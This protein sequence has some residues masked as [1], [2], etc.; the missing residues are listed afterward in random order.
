MAKVQVKDWK[1]EFGRDPVK[2]FR[3]A[4]ENPKPG[5]SIKKEGA[6]DKFPQRCNEPKPVMSYEEAKKELEKKALAK[7]AVSA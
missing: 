2:A 3:E 4:I 6:V 1:V 5:E 7:V